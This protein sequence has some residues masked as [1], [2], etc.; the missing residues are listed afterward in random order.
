MDRLRGEGLTYVRIAKQLNV[1]TKTIKRDCIALDEEMT[2][3]PAYTEGRLRIREELGRRF[4]ELYERILKDLDEASKDSM[5]TE[6][7][8][9]AG[10]KKK[11]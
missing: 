2:I 1:S 8:L 7:I 3:E 9:S 4:D 5:T 11:P 10:S 6:L